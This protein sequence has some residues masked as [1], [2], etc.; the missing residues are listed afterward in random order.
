MLRGRLIR[1][2][3][4]SLVK[5]VALVERRA[6]ARVG[7][8]RWHGGG[9]QQS[10]VPVA[11]PQLFPLGSC[12]SFAAAAAAASRSPYDILD[13]SP[14]ASQDDIKKAYRREALK[15]HPD[16]HATNK[17]EAETRYV[18][19]PLCVGTRIKACTDGS[20]WTHLTLSC[21]TAFTSRFPLS[22]VQADLRSLSQLDGPG[23]E[24]EVWQRESRWRRREPEEPV[25][26]PE[27]AAAAVQRRPAAPASSRGNILLRFRPRTFLAR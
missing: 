19:R 24:R 22:Q 7:I 25:W 16:R 13:V 5:R 6:G 26:R 8:E 12:R 20:T 23:H 11:L 17:K 2:S 21:I 15:W 10:V 9:E 1:D 18:S 3:I 14:G 27:T 4:G